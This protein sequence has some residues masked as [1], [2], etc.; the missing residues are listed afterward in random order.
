MKHLLLVSLGP[1][2]EFIAEARRTR[3]LWFGSHVLSEISKAA[4]KDIAEQPGARLIFPALD[5][6][7][8][9]L[10]PCDAP[11]H[12]DGT[13]ARSVANKILALVD[14]AAPRD[15]ARSARKAAKE[16]LCRWGMDVWRQH[17]ELVDPRSE[18]V[19]RE[20]LESFLEFHA[21][22]APYEESRYEALREQLDAEITA[23]KTLHDFSPWIKQRGGIHKSSLDG[24]RESVLRRVVDKEAAQR[25]GGAVPTESRTGAP[26]RAYRIGLRE[27]LDAIGLLKRA[28]GKPEQFVPVPNIGLAAW[29]ELARDH[30]PRLLDD[31]ARDCAG[32]RFQRV[33]RDHRWVTPFPY[34][35]QLFLPDRWGPYFEE[36]SRSRE[37]GEELGARRVRPILEKLA[38]PQPFV[39]CL[40]ADGDRMGDAI[41]ALAKKGHERHRTFSR[42]LADFAEA[43][44]RVVEV[45]HRGILV[46]AGGDDVLAFVCL[47]D[48]LRCAL[49]LKEIFATVMSQ[50]L[51][52]ERNVPAPTL[53]VGVGIGHVLES[54]GDLLRFGR[55]AVHVAKGSDRNALAVLVNKRGGSR[56]I[57]RAQWR[58]NPVSRLEQDIDL[59]E[60][61]A[62]SGKK[63]HQVGDMLRRMPGRSQELDDTTRW[64]RVLRGETLRIL[65]R[66]ETGVDDVPLDPEGV[67]L[68]L[69]ADDYPALR[70]AIARWVERMEIASFL[71]GS[72]PRLRE[73]GAS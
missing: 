42:R 27:E 31:M 7:D 8:P 28:G 67:G 19:A 6:G 2:Q 62:L 13:P 30:A 61:R 72:R 10:D 64:A 51:G 21:A 50:A 48:V 71:A 36:N 29:I 14:S 70:D 58:E 43:A 9:H 73:R 40:V 69:A 54:L 11:R 44:R 17:G 55:E 15:V 18:D 49:K 46:Y 12:D 47:A 25:S 34:D 23:R 39:A 33:H 53:S 5:R 60:R 63:I 57:W 41:A 22:W 16:R 59:L 24:A 65:A 45:D 37:E 1:V 20:Q 32:F 38:P 26:W 52:G 68:E 4:A 56:R 3:D 66:T 35:A